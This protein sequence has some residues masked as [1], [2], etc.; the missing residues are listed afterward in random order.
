MASD[1]QEDPPKLIYMSEHTRRRR[2]NA[3]SG[4]NNPSELER[5]AHWLGR[6]L[7]ATATATTLY[8]TA[9][10]LGITPAGSEEAWRWNASMSVGHLFLAA[11]AGIG[12][13]ALLRAPH[14]GVLWV[15]FAGGAAAVLALTGLLRGPIAGEWAAVSRLEVLTHGLLAALALWTGSFLVRS[16]HGRSR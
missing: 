8:W 13:A 4:G 14:S 3:A 11:T 15:A 5:E 12:G 10:L 9:F 1:Q 16:E 2:R 6:V 7:L